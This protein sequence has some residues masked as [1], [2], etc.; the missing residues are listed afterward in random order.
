MSNLTKLLVLLTV[1]LVGGIL[2]HSLLLSAT[3]FSLPLLPSAAAAL[4]LLL[5]A[6]YV[7][8]QLWQWLRSKS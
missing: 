6:R 2:F 4:L 3:G 8:R 1:L 7:L 5:T